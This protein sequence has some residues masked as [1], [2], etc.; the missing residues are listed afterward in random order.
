METLRKAAAGAELN[1]V[2]V[3]KAAQLLKEEL[4]E[5]VGAD[6]ASEAMLSHVA[7]LAATAA[8]MKNY[9]AE[10]WSKDV[11]I[12]ESFAGVIESVR[13]KLQTASKPARRLRR[14]TK[15]E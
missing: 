12:D 9:E 14:K 6:D 11:A 13:V 15:M 5:K 8:N 2:D 7:A 1:S 10:A 3:A 4:G